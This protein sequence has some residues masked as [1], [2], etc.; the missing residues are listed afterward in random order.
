[1][2]CS[3]LLPV[4]AALVI[5]MALPALSCKENSPLLRVSVCGDLRAPDDVDTLRVT[6][7]D[8]D[9]T[10]T[11][12][13][14]VELVPPGPR[15]VT[16]DTSDMGVPDGSVSDAGPVDLGVVDAGVGDG[17]VGD[18]GLADAGP[19]C[20]SDGVPVRRGLSLP[21]P[22]GRGW[23]EVI[24]L[25][26]GVQVVAAEVR[27]PAGAGDVAVLLPLTV[28]CL[29]VTCPLGQTCR[30]GACVLVPERGDA[31]ACRTACAP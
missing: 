2:R 9:R 6:V 5:A 11:Y 23:V 10:E 21:L 4:G 12:A 27:A 18:G 28:A 19:V 30:S 1:M 17:G 31:A 7:R 29:G 25:R 22:K 3:P 16:P 15:T 20:S 26:A 24:G 14:I 13:G 8:E